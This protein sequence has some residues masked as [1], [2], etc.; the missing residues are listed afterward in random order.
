MPFTLNAYLPSTK[1]EIQIKELCYKQYRELVK[2]LYSI[3]KK[4][5]IQQ[6]NS[7]LLE[8]CP[9]IKD[10][11]ITFEDKL[12]LLLTIRN[13]CVS[14]DL[15]LKGTTTEGNTFNYSV[16]V[17][18][19]V[20]S[21]KTINKSSVIEIGNIKVG[22]SSYK[23]RDEWVFI[24]NNKDIFDKLASYIDYIIFN[25]KEVFFKGLSLKERLKII[26]ALP[27]YV[28][29]RI[30]ESI[31]EIEEYY[32]TQPLL[33]VVNPINKDVALTITKNIDYESLQKLIEFIFTEE[34]NNIYRAFYNMVKYAG[35]TPQYIDSITPIEMQVYWMYYNQD[36]EASKE[37][38]GQSSGAFP[39][40]TNKELGF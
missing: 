15:K 32:N 12:S 20:Q 37:S 27:H 17:D 3:D 33:Q 21:V 9:D 1:E 16:L 19:L 29:N 28:F 31:L 40:V 34:L 18:T 30:Y 23:V 5:T 7:I 24:G 22:Y 38:S 6:Y 4:E 13:Y 25:N 8:L 26:C 2:S 14:P 35:F 36:I 39:S 10:K 11:D